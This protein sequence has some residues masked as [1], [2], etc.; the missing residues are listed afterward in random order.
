MISSRSENAQWRLFLYPR[1]ALDRLPPA[2]TAVLALALVHG[3]LLWKYGGQLWAQEHYRFFPV[4]WGALLLLLWHRAG[5]MRTN[6]CTA[7]LLGMDGGLVL[8][9]A[10]LDSPLVG[11]AGFLAGCLAVLLASQDSITGRSLWPL[12]F[13]PLLTFRLPLQLDLRLIQWLQLETT[14]AASGILERLQ[15]L[16]HRA[17]VI[18]Q[19]PN[20]DL[21]VDETC[22][23]I[24]SLFTLFGLAIL[25]AVIA[26]RN[27]LAAIVLFASAA[28]WAHCLNV[29][30]VVIVVLARVWWDY[31]LAN[32]WPHEVLGYV[33]VAVSIICLLSTD[34]LL[35]ILTAPLPDSGLV[36]EAAIPPLIRAF[37]WLFRPP[38]QATATPAGSGAGAIAVAVA[39]GRAGRLRRGSARRPGVRLSG[40]RLPHLATA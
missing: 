38:W 4:M 17:G 23:G 29:V 1:T 35:L 15:I 30:R 32:G 34:R 6:W 33:L 27:W 7:V 18:L 14:R 11:F 8:L 20:Q 5:P 13:L 10:W 3:L 9:S 22:S 21:F 2:L 26:R 25:I 37:N 40:G 36:D 19:L 16:H 28:V 12:I 24:Q 39:A 31:D